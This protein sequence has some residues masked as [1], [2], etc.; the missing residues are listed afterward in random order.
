M[1]EDKIRHNGP[2]NVD[3]VPL[4]V[5][6]TAASVYQFLSPAEEQP[7]KKRPAQNMGCGSATT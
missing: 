5:T 7:T 4:G 1:W 2:E 6:A 3:S